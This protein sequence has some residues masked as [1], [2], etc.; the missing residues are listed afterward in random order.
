MKYRSRFTN[1]TLWV[2]VYRDTPGDIFRE[3]Y[4]DEDDADDVN[5]DPGFVTGPPAP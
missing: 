1:D 4:G 3:R 5:L 2:E